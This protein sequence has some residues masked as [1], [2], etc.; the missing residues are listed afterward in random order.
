MLLCSVLA[1]SDVLAAISIVKYDEQPKL[2][3]VIFGEGI[4]NDAVCIILFNSVHIYS[5][6][7]EFTAFSP[8]AMTESFI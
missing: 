4:V 7:E 6:V 2:F 3:S 1:S 8:L 5:T